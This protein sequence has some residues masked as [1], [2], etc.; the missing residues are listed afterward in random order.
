M[1]R[2]KFRI[3]EEFCL[4]D[5]HFESEIVYKCFLNIDILI[6]Y[7][8][9]LKLYKALKG[10]KESTHFKYKDPP[11]PHLLSPPIPRTPLPQTSRHLSFIQARE[12]I[13]PAGK[14]L[15]AVWEPCERAPTRV[16]RLHS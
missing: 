11:L 16:G 9:L 7:T 12:F 5:V 15:V 13:T 10:E 1:F 8:F 3:I 14:Q 4:T 2:H 6:K